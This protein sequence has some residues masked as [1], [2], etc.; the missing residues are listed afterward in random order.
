M[1]EL[2]GGDAIETEIEGVG[3]MTVDVA[4]RDVSYA[5]ASVQQGGQ[6]EQV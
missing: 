4:G 6:E 2:H 1:S 5:D 3:S